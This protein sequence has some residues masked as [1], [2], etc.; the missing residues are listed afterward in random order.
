VIDRI[1]FVVEELTASAQDVDRIGL[2]V[3]VH[4]ELSVTSRPCFFSQH[5]VQGVNKVDCK[6][7][8]LAL[9]VG[10]FRG[11]EGMGHRIERRADRYAAAIVGLFW[12]KFAARCLVVSSDEVVQQ[13]FLPRQKRSIGFPKRM[14]TTGLFLRCGC[15]RWLLFL[16]YRTTNQPNNYQAQCDHLSDRIHNAPRKPFTYFYRRVSTVNLKDSLIH[17][18]RCDFVAGNASAG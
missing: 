16:L 13:A 10:Q 9:F 2:Q 8:A 17:K 15:F 3:N 7:Q 1:V 18:L 11:K 6:S 12:N 4:T 14:W 5:L